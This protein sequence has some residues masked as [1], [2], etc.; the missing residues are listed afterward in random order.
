MRLA[1]ARDLPP[2]ARTD[3]RTRTLSLRRPML[4]DRPGT[5]ECD[6][7]EPAARR[8]P[9]TSTTCQFRSLCFVV[10]S[11]KNMPLLVRWEERAKHTGRS[12]DRDP[13][14]R[15]TIVQTALR[16]PTRSASRDGRLAEPTRALHQIPSR[17]AARRGLRSIHHGAVVA[18]SRGRY[19]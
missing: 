9:S 16:D 17:T 2:Q 18:T 7:R 10:R 3:G 4:I 1:A 19:R 8:G 11:V 13:R 15:R 12:G 14:E 5:C 6:R